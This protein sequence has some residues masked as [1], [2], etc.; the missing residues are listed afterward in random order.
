MPS[1]RSMNSPA[2][3]FLSPLPI[4]SLARRFHPS[5]SLSSKVRADRNHLT[6]GALAPL[7]LYKSS[8]RPRNVNNLFPS[9]SPTLMPTA[10]GAKCCQPSLSAVEAPRCSRRRPRAPHAPCALTESFPASFEPLPTPSPLSTRCRSFS[11]SRM[12]R[13]RL[14]TSRRW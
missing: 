12:P 3:S 6:P 9:L 11:P 4:L 10:C 5:I 8:Q 13:A 2:I 1:S 14:D 7:P